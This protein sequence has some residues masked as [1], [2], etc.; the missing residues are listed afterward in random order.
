MMRLV[1]TGDPTASVDVRR[2]LALAPGTGVWLCGS[3]VWS[4]YPKRDMYGR[5]LVKVAAGSFAVVTGRPRVHVWFGGGNVWSRTWVV[6]MLGARGAMWVEW[7]EVRWAHGTAPPTGDE[8]EFIVPPPAGDR[9]M[10]ARDP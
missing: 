6:P 5:S 3:P 7:D 9:H 4:C 2:F 1:S 8:A 10:Q